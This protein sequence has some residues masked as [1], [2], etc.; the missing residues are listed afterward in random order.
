MY[1]SEGPR[2][3]TPL[4]TPQ[5]AAYLPSSSYDKL[6]PSPQLVGSTGRH[7][8]RLGSARTHVAPSSLQY[9]GHEGT[10]PMHSTMSQQHDMHE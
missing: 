8:A 7:T 3:S 2:L 9:H 10:A 4:D 6:V 5:P 1:C